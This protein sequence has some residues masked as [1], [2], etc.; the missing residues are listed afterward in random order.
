[1]HTAAGP[2]GA[3]LVEH[4]FRHAY[5]KLV[6]TLSRRAG[7]QHLAAIEDAAQAALMAALE[8]WGR[9]GLPDQPSAWLFKV[10]HHKLI[11]D[12]RQSATRHRLLVQEAATTPRPDG[13]P[14]AVL[15]GEVDDDLL[16]M[17]FACCDDGLAPA[18]QLALALKTLC[19]FSVGEIA[20]RLFTNE[21]TIY[22]RLGRAR[23]RLRESPPD[24][25]ALGGD[26]M[27]GRVPAVQQVLY[28]L[29]TE[30]HLSSHAER[31]IRRELV[32][33]ALR[34][35][36]LLAAHPVG[37]T[38]QTRALLALMCLHAARL[39]AREDA[40]GGLLLLE[41]QDRARWDPTLTEEGM[42]WLGRSAEGDVYSRF[43]AEAAIAAEHAMAPSYAETRWDKVAAAY[44]L[45][46]EVAPSPVHRL[47]RAVAV[48]EHEGPAAGLAVLD[49]F[50]PPPW[51]TASYLFSAVLADLHRRAGHEAQAADHRR[52]ALEGAPTDAVRTLLERRFKAS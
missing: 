7:V 40:D 37:D 21:A 32:D 49:G 52:A 1:V 35:G 39:P 30:G 36:R 18:A 14:E 38:P 24:L 46:E 22:K 48:G 11:D 6:A 4:F 5:G 51:L 2:D 12:L 27:R 13:A 45:L 41:E 16:R 19:G 3:D 28:L 25:E 20:Q 47:N 15:A 8:T 44:A 50:V 33:E 23:Q 17:L 42:R 43:H 29:F 31:A 10:A 26:A 9:R 34:L